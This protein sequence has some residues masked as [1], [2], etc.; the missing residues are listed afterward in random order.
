LNRAVLFNDAVWCVNCFSG[1][2]H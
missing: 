2:W 1:C